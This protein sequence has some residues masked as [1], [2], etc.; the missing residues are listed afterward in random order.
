MAGVSYDTPAPARK[1][2][3]ATCGKYMH[4]RQRV[5]PACGVEQPRKQCDADATGTL[6]SYV[7]TGF[8]VPAPDPMVAP[9]ARVP[10]P[11]A[12]PYSERNSGSQG[13]SKPADQMGG[14]HRKKSK[15]TEAG[16]E[17]RRPA[18]KFKHIIRIPSGKCPVQLDKSADKEAVTKWVQSVKAHH[19]TKNE[20]LMEEGMV[21][22]AGTMVDRFSAEFRQIQR[23]IEDV[24]KEEYKDARTQAATRL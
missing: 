7:H 11:D 16:S 24:Y 2:C 3:Y 19:D 18:R 6:G 14:L 17:Y 1:L 9:P 23:H 20:W 13:Q 22:Y 8:S 21:Y 10:G 4:V 5:C 15:A 12:R